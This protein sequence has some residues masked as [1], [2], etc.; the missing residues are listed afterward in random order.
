MINKDTQLCISVASRPGNF[1]TTLHNAAYA[2]LG[3]NFVYKAC[4]ITDIAATMVGVRAL[5]IR[6]CSVSMPF[7]EAVIT[8]LD[9]LDETAQVIGAV[10]TIVNDA[11][12]L[13]GY[14]TDVIGARVALEA[15]QAR[16]SESVLLLGAG[17]AA[18]AIL[19]AL[20]QIGFN[21]VRVAGRDLEKIHRLDTILS[22]QPVAWAER[23]KAPVDLVINATSVGMNPNAESM[24]LEEAFIQQS[25]AVMD[26]VISP[27]ETRLI[28]CA[29]SAGKGVAPGYLMSLEQ[30]MAQFTLY[31]GVKPPRN[32]M[33]QDMRRLLE[34]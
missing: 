3:L 20:R 30:T 10:N 32:L 13:T 4:G 19:F 34:L 28:G 22:C 7:K 24:P 15:L 29:R 26:V 21:Q 16:P 5:G 23:Q 17:G 31:T 27:I 12:R 25:R 33:E 1:G 2:A 9:E 18:R 8:Y 11:G 6:G 14:N